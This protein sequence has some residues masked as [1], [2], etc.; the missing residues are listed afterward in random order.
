MRAA[1]F[2]QFGGPEVLEI[3]DLPTAVNSHE[4]ITVPAAKMRPE[5]TNNR[6]PN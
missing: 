3:A 4:Q 5:L 1:S 2:S 6:S